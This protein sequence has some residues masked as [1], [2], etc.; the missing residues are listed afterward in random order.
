MKKLGGTFIFC[1]VVLI[2]GPFFGFT[3]RGQGDLDYGSSFMLGIIS[4][5][6]GLLFNCLGKGKE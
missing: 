4:L 6:V 3:I 2:V 5:G 1:G